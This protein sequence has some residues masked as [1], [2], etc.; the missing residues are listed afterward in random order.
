MKIDSYANIILTLD[1]LFEQARTASFEEPIELAKYNI[2]V[3]LIETQLKAIE[4]QKL[5]DTNSIDETKL[6]PFKITFTELTV[7]DEKKGIKTKQTNRTIT[8]KK[9]RNGL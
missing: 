6:T 8:A 1:K 4:K 9:S 3:K 5:L 2:M 7:D